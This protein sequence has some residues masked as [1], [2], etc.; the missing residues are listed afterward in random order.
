MT[1]PRV[2]GDQAIVTVLVEVSPEEAFRVF[3]EEI[4]AWWRVGLRYRIGR[5]RSVVH[6]EPKLGGRLFESYTTSAG[7]RVLES[8]RVTSWTPPTQLTFEWRASNF[9]PHEKTEVDVAFEP[10]PSG[11]LVTVRHR[12]F[13]ALRPD[14]P[15]R[16]GAPPAAFIR[17]M[18]LW[19]GDLM[20]SLR[21]HLAH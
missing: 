13:A 11:T 17:N 12:G 5:G 2:V 10:S 8:G 20:S 1:T 19:W 16:H 3:T 15:V 4:D 9:A 14:H 7:E 21:N 18:S 6:L